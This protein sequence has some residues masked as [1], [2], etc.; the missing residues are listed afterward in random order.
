METYEA[1]IQ[2]RQEEKIDV[3]PTIKELINLCYNLDCYEF[4]P[5]IRNDR[6]LGEVCL[7][8]GISD[9]IDRLSDDVVELL[10]PEKVGMEQR[11]AM[12]FQMHAPGRTCM[13]ENTCRISA[14]FLRGFFRF[15]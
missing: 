12:H 6:E 1:A 14:V 10:D 8:G 4:R 13:M 7:D 11:R 9:W 15:G 5:E 2:M 3:P